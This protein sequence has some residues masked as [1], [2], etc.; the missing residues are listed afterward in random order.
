MEAVSF[1]SNPSPFLK[2]STTSTS[3]PPLERIT[4][5]ESQIKAAK[6]RPGLPARGLDGHSAWSF[7]WSYGLIICRPSQEE[8]PPVS[9]MRRMYG[10]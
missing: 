8:F 6:K 5:C 4:P 3:S 2:E 1:R 9:A 10:G 7:L